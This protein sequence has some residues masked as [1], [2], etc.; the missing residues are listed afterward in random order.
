ME[1]R[2]TWQLTRRRFYWHW[3]LNISFV[4][5]RSLFWYFYLLSQRLKS[6]PSGHVDPFHNI[7]RNCKAVVSEHRCHRPNAYNLFW[8]LGRKCKNSDPLLFASWVV[9]SMRFALLA[10]SQWWS[11]IISHHSETGWG[12]PFESYGL[13]SGSTRFYYSIM[14]ASVAYLWAKS[15]LFRLGRRAIQRGWI[16]GR[17]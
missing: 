12:L 1:M 2:E 10:S 11:I 14:T 5:F 16:R 6:C 4:G 17:K 8:Q 3:G 9:R 7:V 13:D 15:R